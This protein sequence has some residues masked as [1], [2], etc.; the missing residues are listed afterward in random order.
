MKSQKFTFPVLA[1]TV[2][3]FA[4]N[5]DKR[6]DNTSKVNRDSLVQVDLAQFANENNAIV[7]P[8]SDI[9]FTSDLQNLFLKSRRIVFNDFELV[10]IF[11]KDTTQFVRLKVKDSDNTY[12]VEASTTRE[13]ASHLKSDF[14]ST[15]SINTLNDLF[16]M[17]AIDTFYKSSFDLVKSEKADEYSYTTDVNSPTAFIIKGRLTNTQFTRV[18]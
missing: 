5:G 16:I 11:S 4:C 10:D 13:I 9:R 14:D 17:C 7:F 2:A 6:E 15:L 1:I 18:K 12:F 8:P 3:L